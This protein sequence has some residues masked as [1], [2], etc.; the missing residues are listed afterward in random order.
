MSDL[1]ALLSA[2]EPVVRRAGAYILTA[3]PKTVDEKSNHSDLVT[4]F[5]VNTQ[6]MLTKELGQIH[7]EASFMGE[8]EHLSDGNVLK[9][10]TFVIDPID[11]TTNFV[12]GYCRS[13]ISVALLW[14]GVP[15]LGAVYNPWSDEYYT[16]LKGE[17]S[18]CNGKPLR[19]RTG[20]LKDSVVGCG[21]CPYYP[22]LAQRTLRILSAVMYQA[23]DIRRMGSAAL[24]L[25]DLAMGRTGAFFELKLSPWDYAAAGLIV[26]EAGGLISDED[27]NP[28]SFETAT[29]VVAGAPLA[30]RELRELMKAVK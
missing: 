18:F 24:D 14:D 27:G 13:A 21:T 9:G 16:A 30:Y 5:D 29:P 8:E 11:G 7:P 4:E 6:R 26:T 22:D 20:G 10:D 23:I 12:M 19:V 25:C 28:L 1:H 3:V 17:G 2:I 15:V